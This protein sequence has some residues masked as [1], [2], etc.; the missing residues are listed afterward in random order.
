MTPVVH[1][2]WLAIE[3][4]LLNMRRLWF[5]GR[6]RPFHC[7]QMV[8]E[9]DGTLIGLIKGSATEVDALLAEAKVRRSFVVVTPFTEPA[10]IRE[11][12]RRHGFHLVQEQGTYVYSNSGVPTPP[13]RRR[14]WGILR[15]HATVDVQEMRAGDLPVWNRTCRLAF[16]PRGLTEPE[17]LREKERAYRA[18]GANA[19]W[20]L[21]VADSRP[22]GT[23][24]LYQEGGIAQLLAV[25]TAPGMRRRGVA[26][27]LVARA[28]GDCQLGPDGFLFLDTRPGSAAERLYLQLGFRL[29]YVRQIFVP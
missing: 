11:R 25:G 26:S 22:V 12:L 8:E 28:V 21:A 16:G 29:A 2:R 17:S 18:M 27:A 15:P 23:C 7:G 3:T 19:R 5:E 13:P 10:D 1:P 14:L 6:A 4:T 20:Y 9:Q 24:I